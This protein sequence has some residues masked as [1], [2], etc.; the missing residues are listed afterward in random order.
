MTEKTTK[1]QAIILILVS[2]GVFLCLFE[3]ILFLVGIEPSLRN[4]DPF[5]GFSSNVPL[6]VSTDEE[7]VTAANRLSFFNPQRFPQKKSPDSYRIFCLGGST[8]YGRPYDDKTAF[9][10]WLRELLQKIDSS[11]EWE[12]IN[13]GGISYAS[14]RVAHL[15]EE[16]IHYQPDLFII[17]TGHNEFLEERTYSKIKQ[18]PEPI[19]EAIAF[20]ARTRVWTAVDSALKYLGLN[21]EQ[22]E[23]NKN[24]LA[25]QVDAILERSAGLDLYTRD[26]PLVEN[27]LQHFELSLNL[28]VD[29]AHSVKAK[30][31]FVLPASNLKDCSPFKSQ[32]TENLSNA[33]QLL[34]EQMLENALVEMKQ[35]NFRESL[36][37]LA[38]AVTLNP[39][40]AALQ[41]YRGKALLNLGHYNKAEAALVRARDEDVCPLRAMT[42]IIEVVSKVAEKEQVGMVDFVDLLSKHTKHLQGH[43]IPGEEFFLDHVHPTIQ[44]HKILAIALVKKMIEDGIVEPDSDWE[45]IVV[46]A[47]EVEVLNRIDVK[48][49]AL[50]LANLARVMYWAQKKTEAERLAKQALEKANGDPNSSINAISTLST[51]YMQK[52]EHQSA[53]QLLYD[54]LEKFPDATELRLQLGQFLISSPLNELEKAAANFLFVTKTVPDYDNAHAFF[55][56]IMAKKGRPEIA[57]PSLMESLRLNPNNLRAQ[58]SLEQVRRLLENQKPTPWPAEIELKAYSSGGPHRLTQLRKN[59]TGEFIS[60]GVEVEFH[61][62]GRIKNFKVMAKGKIIEEATWNFE[63]ENL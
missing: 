25:T 11:R 14:Y 9:S 57:Y 45:N 21:R 53:L 42:K 46:P 59:V 47:V 29:L 43:H 51:I 39:R 20:T 17:Y 5:V 18:L 55:G 34:T 12:I 13:A 35:N 30:V 16:L 44:G 61:R 3:G 56:T 27:I 62:N 54:Y 10:G 36:N 7:M 37:I 8:T 15:M 24:M 33:N 52:G 49:H 22:N 2:T 32:H 40:H 26:D 38:S 6:F 1:F 60:D 31:I 4:E 23:K 63:G 28:M 48:A 41:Y 19:R 58:K 50:A